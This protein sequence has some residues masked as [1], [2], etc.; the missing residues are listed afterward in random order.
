MWVIDYFPPVLGETA[1]RKLRRALS[2]E[3]VVSLKFESSRLEQAR[4]F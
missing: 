1:E 3:S 2:H 4:F